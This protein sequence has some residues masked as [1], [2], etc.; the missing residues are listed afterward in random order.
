ML[1]PVGCCRHPVMGVGISTLITADTTFPRP[2][3][4]AANPVDS[5]TGFCGQLPVSRKRAV[6]GRRR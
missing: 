1:P 4:R 3:V 2:N 5:S 6:A